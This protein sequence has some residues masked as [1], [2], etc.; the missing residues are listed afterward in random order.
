MYFPAPFSL[1]GW[2]SGLTLFAF[3]WIGRTLV[4]HERQSVA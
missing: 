1:G 2:V 3:A 4:Q